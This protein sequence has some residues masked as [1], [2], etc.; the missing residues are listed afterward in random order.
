MAYPRKLTAL[1][2]R[3]RTACARL[4]GIGVT[5]LVL[6]APIEGSVGSIT[7]PVMAFELMQKD[8]NEG[9]EASVA[10]WLTLSC[11]TARSDG[12]HKQHDARETS[13]QE[14]SFKIPVARTER[15]FGN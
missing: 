10:R 12:K 3:T 5:W 14:R 11:K 9:W 6:A 15:R 13:E 8:P 1:D 2:E 7:S 4:Q